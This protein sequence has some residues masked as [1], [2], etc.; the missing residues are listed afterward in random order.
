MARC[1]SRSN[2]V[3]HSN[4]SFGF[5]PSATTRPHNA[6]AGRRISVVV[7][8]YGPIGSNGGAAAFAGPPIQIV[9][10]APPGTEASDLVDRVRPDVVLVTVGEGRPYTEADMRGVAL[11]LSG[12]SVNTDDGQHRFQF[13]TDMHHAGPVNI[14]GGTFVTSGHT[15]S[16]GLSDGVR[17]LNIIARHPA[18][19]RYI[20]YKLCR[21]FVADTPP[22]ALVASAAAVYTQN[23][24]AIAPVLRH[25]F[26]SAAFASGPRNKVR[27]GFEVF[28][29]YDRAMGG[30]A[31]PDPL[32]DLANHLHG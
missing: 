3:S 5:S 26:Q 24:T 22:P 30:T 19:A 7:V 25:I 13:K 1:E 10:H 32:G 9:G 17:L 20:A 23:D 14:L 21:R 29:A 16:A 27:R 12:W 15:G 28:V 31:E 6:F 4:D 2:R 11:T 18:T 8:D